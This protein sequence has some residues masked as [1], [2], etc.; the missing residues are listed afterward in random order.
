MGTL[1][2]SGPRFVAS[3]LFLRNLPSGYFLSTSGFGQGLSLDKYFSV[4]N[5]SVFFLAL[6]GDRHLDTFRLWEGLSCGSIPLLVDKD[7]VASKLLPHNFP[8]PIFSTWPEALN[9]AVNLLNN[10]ISLKQLQL[11]TYLWW[12]SYQAHVKSSIFYTLFA[13]SPAIH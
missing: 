13:P 10:P 1:W 4:F 2:S 8:L 3:S 12:L 7:Y 5:Q 6:P 9:Y 11:S